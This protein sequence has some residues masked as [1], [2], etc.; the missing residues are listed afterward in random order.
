[1]EHREQSCHINTQHAG[2]SSKMTTGP[3]LYRLRL[4][5]R[6]SLVL[7]KYEPEVYRLNGTRFEKNDSKIRSTIVSSTSAYQ[8]ERIS[9]IFVL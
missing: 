6:K 2:S 7:L 4:A 8:S 5:Q 1:M 9:T 3:T